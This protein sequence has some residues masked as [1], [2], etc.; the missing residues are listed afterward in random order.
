MRSPDRERQR[1]GPSAAAESLRLVRSMG[2]PRRDPQYRRD[3]PHRARLGD[4]TL[5]FNCL[6]ARVLL[7]EGEE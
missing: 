7:A 2:G 3:F 6:W 5:A 4:P 1:P